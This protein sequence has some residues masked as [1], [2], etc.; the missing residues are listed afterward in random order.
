MGGVFNMPEEQ[1]RPCQGWLTPAENIRCLIGQSLDN[2]WKIAG[3][4]GEVGA[5][6]HDTEAVVKH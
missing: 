3:K 1:I 5:P 2:K 6:F 4:F